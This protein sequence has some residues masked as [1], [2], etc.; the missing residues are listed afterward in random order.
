MQQSTLIKTEDGV[1]FR[2]LNKNGKL[3]VYEDRRQPITARVEDLLGRMT[4]AE[5]AGTMFIN[6]SVVN[7]DGSIEEKPAAAGSPRAASSQMT[8]QQMTHF[9]LWEIPDAQAVAAWYNN[10]Q[11]FA[12]ETRLGIPV[13]IASDPRNHFSHNIFAMA[14]TDFS[15][16]CET[17]GFGALARRGT[18]AAVRGYGPA[19]VSGCGDSRRAAPADRPGNRAALGPHQ[20]HLRRGRAVDGG[21]RRGLH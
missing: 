7:A 5:K 21:A 18:G 10:L 19:R 2:D 3:D 11:H 16:W 13:T 12:E 20:R 14:A 15:Q 6:G 8:E 1:T 4:L 9:N 17:L